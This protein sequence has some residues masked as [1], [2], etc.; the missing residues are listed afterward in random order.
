MQGD[1]NASS[2]LVPK[3]L[4]IFRTVASTLHMHTSHIINRF[5]APRMRACVV[6]DGG[7]A[8]ALAAVLAA[9]VDMDTTLLTCRP[10][11]WSKRVKVMY[12]DDSLYCSGELYAVGSDPAELVAAADV[13]LLAGPPSTADVELARVAPHLK[14]GALLGSMSGATGFPP[15]AHKHL[16]GMDVDVFATREQPYVARVVKAGSIV[17]FDGRAVG[18]AVA[19]FPADRAAAVAKRAS[20]LL[21]IPCVPLPSCE[22]GVLA[23]TTDVLC[24]IR[25]YA[26]FRDWDGN[27]A[28]WGQ[29]PLMFAEWDAAALDVALACDAEVQALR[30]ASSL[31]T[32]TW[33]LPQLQRRTYSHQI[34]DT[35]S[36][37]AMLRSNSALAHLEVPMIRRG[38]GG[39]W[40]PDVRAPHL[41]DG[42]KCGLLAIKALALQLGAPTPRLDDV[43]HWAQRMIACNAPSGSETGAKA[44]LDLPGE[45]AIAAKQC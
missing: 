35:S 40:V 11:S 3:S 27:S 6:G 16:T 9:R 41:V 4:G 5:V 45:R 14:A 1:D 2:Y 38:G 23:L 33:S 8:M 28:G 42:V 21:G 20:S 10:E 39:D 44:A 37:L 29:A 26:L 31:D 17:R 15:L 19:A 43:L 34:K 24:V 18:L 32:D 12:S 30:R 13:V 22:E 7:A 25:M 36:P